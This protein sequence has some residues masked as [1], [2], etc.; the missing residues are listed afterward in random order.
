MPAPNKRTVLILVAAIL[1]SALS[2]FFAITLARLT[3]KHHA[4]QGGDL[5]ADGPS[6]ATAPANMPPLNEAERPA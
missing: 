1:M 6:T 5:V 4:E 3:R 2:T